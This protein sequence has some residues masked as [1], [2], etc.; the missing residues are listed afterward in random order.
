MGERKGKG[1]R[2]WWEVNVDNVDLMYESMKVINPIR[3]FFFLISV[4]FIS[5]LPG[6]S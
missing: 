2:G 3:E 4:I 5:N 1:I 6:S